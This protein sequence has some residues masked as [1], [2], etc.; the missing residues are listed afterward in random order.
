MV[1]KYPGDW[2]LYNFEKDRTELTNLIEKNRAKAEE[3]MKLY[4]EWFRRCDILPWDRL[5][6]IATDFKFWYQD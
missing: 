5:K 6:G 2:E 1:K 3:L 4:D